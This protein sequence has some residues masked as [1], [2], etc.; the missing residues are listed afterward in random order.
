[1]KTSEG[2][3]RAVGVR[4]LTAAIINFTVGAGI[5]VLPAVVAG[6]IGN[7]API[8]YLI[9]A[10]AM[11]LIVMCFAEAG[12][13]VSL[14]GGTY[15]YAEVAFGPY[16]GFMVAMFLWFGSAV[17]ASA[18]V[19]NVFVDAVAQFSPVLGTSVIRAII[20]LAVYGGLAIV[21]IRGVKTG[22]GVVQTVTAAKLLPLLI[23]VGVGL[24]AVKG[25]NMTWPGMPSGADLARTSI[26]LIFA[27]TGVESA[28]TPS[29]EVINPARTV[30][31]A[32]FTALLINTALYI[33]IQV[34]AQGVLGVGLATNTKAPLAAVAQEILGN[35]GRI[36]ILIGTAISTFGYVAGDMLASPRSVFALGRDNLLPPITSRVN[37][38]FAT[39][40]VAI[41]IHAV[42][43][44]AL[45]ISGSFVTLA[46]VAVL[47]CL[48]VYLVC[49]LATLELRR[50]NVRQEG[51]IPFRVPGGP[52]IPV[53]AV[54]VVI[55][56]MSSSTKQEFFAV[57][58][59]FVISTLLFFGMRFTRASS[60]TI[61]Q[62]AEK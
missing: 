54:A 29:G 48:V 21:N 10:A 51:A 2:L 25:V 60:P 19:V 52:V 53:L 9:C 39:P 37:D 31:R 62:V 8:A 49:C 18:A 57:G 38:R 47:A 33:A 17:L 16:V 59:M 34:V 4:G 36:L 28:L 44:A 1:M 5:F 35:G 42:F 15:A 56:L 6:K 41:I 7:A 40:H 43:C 13:R 11:A 23:L 30:P 46:V 26:V 24:F 3:I 14:S 50:K 61:P 58:V 32:I 12:S 20:I 45:A 22:S 27:F 55:W